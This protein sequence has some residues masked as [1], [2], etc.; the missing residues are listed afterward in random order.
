MPRYVQTRIVPEFSSVR[1]GQTLTLAIDQ[2]IAEHW[3]VYWK[4][5]GD[6]GEALS[7]TWTLPPGFSAGDMQ[8]PVPSRI[9]IGPLLN[10][11]YSDHVTF[12]TDITVPDVSG[13]SVPV[14][15]E[16]AWLVCEE[17]CVPEATTID[18]TLPVAKDGEEPQA[19]DPDLFR[20]ARAAM[21]ESAD[22]PGMVEE[23]DGML[24]L[25]FTLDDAASAELKAATAIE[26]F[27]DEWGIILNAA[28]QDNRVEDRT[29]EL[30]LSRDTRELQELG[31]QITGLVAYTSGTDGKKAVRV[32]LPVAAS[33]AVME[34][35]AR[36]TLSEESGTRPHIKPIT[37]WQALSLAL[38]GGLVLNLMPCVFP[39]L[40][41]KALSLVKMS[42]QEQAHAVTHGIMYT[43]GI[44]VSFSL[45]AAALMTLQAAGNQ[46]GWGFQMQNPVV[47]LLLAYLLFLMGLNLSGMFEIGSSRVANLGS[48]LSQTKGYAG[49][50]FTGMLATVVAT[51][52]TAPFMGAAMGYAVTQSPLT[53]L[54]IFIALGTGLALPYLLLTVLPPLRRALPRP[55]HW[56]ETFRQFLAF[57][58][59]AS[60]AWLVW[61][62]GQQIEGVYGI[63]LA[64]LGL[65]FIALGIWIW[66]NAPQ[67]QPARTFV[68][69]TAVASLAL[70]V[71]IAGLSMV[72][73]IKT[74]SA[75]NAA[76]AVSM[77]HAGNWKPY[78]RATLDDALKGNDPV[79]VNMTASWCITCK[80]NER[81]A[82]AVDD[83]QRIFSDQKV[84]Y[85]IGDWTNQNPEVTAY[86]SSYGRTGVPLY[87]YYGSRDLTTNQRPEP[88]VLPQLLTP[89][90]IADIVTY[91]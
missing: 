46:I 17:I 29:L 59:Y 16:L 65:V 49:S 85:L 11:G 91:H 41:M 1:P 50:F 70:A 32:Q 4:N 7:V 43:C 87:V 45:I 23:R 71:T 20:Q 26:F 79:F 10:Y 33:P 57:P 58:L 24:Q 83:T 6:S 54:S 75:E 34:R 56:M 8:W 30:H 28:P 14:K 74:E 67:R 3:H 55:G 37:L 72:K 9:P 73:P 48:K 27:P 68:H 77:Q 47:V 2:E 64:G 82:L 52:C 89:G 90:L 44:L 31:G 78:S 80:V 25:N 51:P 5:P 40:S 63:L 88:V 12:L 60:T 39:V 13:E 66:K 86:L 35:L 19:T 42:A 53:A 15:A 62:Y 18:F 84:L 76:Q 69:G 22:W 36:E 38:L 21:P 81:V 61:V